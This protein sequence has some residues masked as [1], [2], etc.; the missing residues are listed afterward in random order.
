MA[1][2]FGTLADAWLSHAAP[3]GNLA[4]FEQ[5]YVSCARGTNTVRLIV[6]TQA[7]ASIQMRFD[8]VVLCEK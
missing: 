8:I 2:Q 1:S 7:N 3:Y 5:F 4:A 6:R